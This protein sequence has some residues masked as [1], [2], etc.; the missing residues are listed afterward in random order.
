MSSVIT[1]VGDTFSTDVDINLLQPLN[2]ALTNT[3]EVSSKETPPSALSLSEGFATRVG[4]DILP[5][6]LQTILDNNNIQLAGRAT[7][8]PR[9]CRPVRRPPDTTFDGLF[10][11]AGGQTFPANT[12]LNQIPAVT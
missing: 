8:N 9:V 5:P 6:D 11:G 4:T 1:R 7:G 2:A 12:P 10:V 3:N